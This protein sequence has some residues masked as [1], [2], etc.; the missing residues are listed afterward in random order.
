[1]RVNEVISRCRTDQSVMI[2]YEHK[3][4]VGTVY[5]ILDTKE[6]KQ[7]RIG[8]MIVPQVGTTDYCNKNVLYIRGVKA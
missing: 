5:E 2:H 6:Y 8:D 7:N 4:I 1:M 3:I